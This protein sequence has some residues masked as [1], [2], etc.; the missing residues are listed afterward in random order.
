MTLALRGGDVTEPPM[1]PE[2]PPPDVLAERLVGDARRLRRLD[3][4]QALRLLEEVLARDPA[5]H[6][7]R[8][9][10]GVLHW[11]LDDSAAAFI[12]WR[13]VVNEAPPDAELH[14]RARLLLALES[15]AR[16]IISESGGGARAQAQRELAELATST[17]GASET[18]R[19]ALLR[20]FGDDHSEPV[21]RDVPGWAAALVRGLS[22]VNEPHADPAATIRDWTTVIDEGPAAWWAYRHRA[23]ARRRAGDV[24]GAIADLDAALARKP[25]RVALLVLRAEARVAMRSL[26]GAI[27][28]LDA[29]LALDPSNDSVLVARGTARFDLGDFA[30]AIAD[31]DASLALNPANVSAFTARGTARLERG[32]LAGALADFDRAVALAPAD[33]AA[34]A[35]RG[36][37]RSASGDLAGALVDLDAAIA[38]SPK[39]PAAW[40]SRATVRERLGDLQRALAD[41]DAALALDPS[42]AAALV[43]RAAARRTAGDTAGALTDCDRALAIDPGL[44]SARFQRGLVFLAMRRMADAAFEFNACKVL[45]PGSPESASA[46]T[47]LAQMQ[48]AGR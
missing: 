21:L 28:D 41:Y 29:A 13:R 32:D 47:M 48:A 45:A 24:P 33:A 46:A 6:D 4:A 9:E 15:M 12:A 44:A 10:I 31:Y 5:R 34:L 22:D 19:L 3:P 1:P 26:P 40:L 35:G 14:A 11:A 18:A 36:A 17:A 25:D 20:H 7:I 37:T 30:G 8:I 16:G 38:A 43:R 27:A 39:Q 23:E 2:A 42:S